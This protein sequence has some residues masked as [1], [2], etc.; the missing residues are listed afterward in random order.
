MPGISPQRVLENRTSLAT[1]PALDPDVD[2]KAKRLREGRID[3]VSNVALRTAPNTTT[4]VTHPACSST[5]VVL[6]MPKDVNAAAETWFITPGNGA[7]TITHASSALARTF[8]F[9][10]FTPA[11][12]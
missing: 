3:T 4:I 12:A 6:L 10:I 1:K 2:R 9:A 11:V 8:R 5:S 7:F